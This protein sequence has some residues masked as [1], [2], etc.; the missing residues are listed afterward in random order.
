M[1]DFTQTAQSIASQIFLVPQSWFESPI[2][3]INLVIP[4]ITTGIFY[5]M[6][7]KRVHVFRNNAVNLTL[8]YCF[9]FI[10]IP[11]FIAKNPYFAIFVSVFAIVTLMGSRITLFRL[12]FAFIAA[13]A[14]LAI[15]SYGAYVIS[16]F[17]V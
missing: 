4:L 12:L 16:L 8:G 10:S 7:L 9:A 1:D 5:Y 6:L 13:V 14:A 15:A 2:F 11:F 3:I 17:A